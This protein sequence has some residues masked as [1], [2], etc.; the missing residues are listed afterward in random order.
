MAWQ[1]RIQTPSYT[2]P[3]GQRIEFLYEDVS[4]S[5]AKKTTAF[6]FPDFE[7]TFVQDR[8]RSGRRIPLRMI[9]SGDDYD[10][11]ADLCEAMLAESGIG[12]L[13]HPKYGTKQVVPF[14]DVHRSDRL[15]TAGN[16]AVI[17]VTFF[18]STDL[19]FPSDTRSASDEL[20][21]AIAAFNAATPIEFA[22][23]LDIGGQFELSALRSA[24]TGTAGRVKENLQAV[25]DFN[26]KVKRQFDNVFN[27]INEGIDTFV[28]DPLSLANQTN[29]LV[30]T[31]ARALAAISDRLDAYGN[32]LTTVT[33]QAVPLPGGDLQTQNKFRSDDLFASNMIVGA[34]ASVLNNQFELRRDA[35]NAA[36]IILAMADQYTAWRDGVLEQSGLDLIDSGLVY[37]QLIDAVGLAGGFLVEL[38]FSLK[39]ERAVV[40]VRPRTAID[41]VAEFYGV[42]DAR[43]DF[44]IVTNDLVGEELLEIPAG[45]RVVYYT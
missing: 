41:L 14:G 32:L 30:Q 17:D 18:E 29:I 19:L 21:A 22:A 3:S 8:G 15:K 13:V 45:R 36:D 43:L 42:V 9:F 16:Q 24:Y 26:A 27:A 12:T 34:I 7:G 38:S 1:D 2:S 44:F 39:Q 33:I 5:F 11:S 35:L 37:Q 10:I 25:A 28:A 31:P 23:T 40:L 6:E 4:Q 20:A